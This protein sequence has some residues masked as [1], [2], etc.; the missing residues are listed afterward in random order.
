[1]IYCLLTA[2]AAAASV[3]T[4]WLTDDV[5]NTILSIYTSFP[6]DVPIDLREYRLHAREQ[7]YSDD[8]E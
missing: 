4:D 7:V 3:S 2:A 5:F 1:M 6:I 8:Y